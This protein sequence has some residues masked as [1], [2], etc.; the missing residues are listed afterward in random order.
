MNKEIPI[1]KC[2]ASCGGKIMTKPTG[3]T[4]LERFKDAKENLEKIKKRLSEFKNQDCKSALLIKDETIPKTEILISELELIK[5]KVEL[6]KICKQHLKEWILRQ[7]YGRK[8]DFTSK[9]TEKG[10]LT[11]QSGFQIIQDV[12]FNG[13]Q[14]FLNKNLKEFEDDYFTGVP[15]L[16][17]HEW[18]LDNKSSWD[19]FTFPIDAEEIPIDGYDYQ[20]RIYLRLLK[21]LN[22]LLCYTLNDIP[23]EILQDEFRSFTFRAK[24]IDYTDQQYYEFAKHLIFTQ[25]GLDE[26][27][28][29]L[30]PSADTS[31][32]IEIPKEKRY[33][34][35][36]IE[37]DLDIEE[38]M[39]KRVLECRKWINANRHKY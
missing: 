25:K 21:K 9:Y 16:I 20:G 30:F 27:K 10:H 37:R 4:N 5:D 28:T 12:Q 31:S 13:L 38:K 24:I 23:I 17:I 19:L 36:L 2:R 14:I 29:F 33:K 39:I 3:K 1:Y 11:E 6:S 34:S 32:F 18:I 15:D 35:F 22:F 8:K 7:K 26:I